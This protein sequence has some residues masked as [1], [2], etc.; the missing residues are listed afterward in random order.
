[1]PKNVT[2]CK[3]L[4]T[5]IKTL[6]MATDSNI[7][8]FLQY[9]DSK[10][11]N[12]NIDGQLA[13][14]MRLPCRVAID[15]PDPNAKLFNQSSRL[16]TLFLKVYD[17]L[18]AFDISDYSSAQ[19]SDGLDGEKNSGRASFFADDLVLDINTVDYFNKYP[20]FLRKF[21]QVNRETVEIEVGINTTIEL[22]GFMR[23]AVNDPIV[24]CAKSKELK[25]D[26]TKNITVIGFAADVK[27]TV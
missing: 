14:I 18:I 3:P 24:R 11:L 8:Q 17:S 12:Q 6:P 4:V 2:V 21:D 23:A 19:F 10:L 25:E 22:N 20:Q 9:F 13:C 1:M 16:T 15:K 7:Q 26:F 5:T 27:Y